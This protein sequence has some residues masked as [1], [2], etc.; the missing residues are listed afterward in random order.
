MRI[1][2]LI[3][4]TA[5]ATTTSVLLASPAMA[6]SLANL[7]PAHANS[8]AAGFS[9]KDCNSPFPDLA[10]SDGW[11]FVLPSSQG[12][13]FV[14]LTLNF[15]GGLV[16][17]PITSTDENSPNTGAGWSGYFDNAGVD[18][19]HAYVSTSPTGLTLL[20]GTAQ[21]TPDG[22]IGSTFNLSHTCPG[23]PA[24]LS[25]SPSA[26][27]SPSPSVSMS[28]M[29]SPS[30]GASTPAPSGGAETGGGGSFGFSLM[31]VGAL[32]MAGGMGVVLFLRRRRDESA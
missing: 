11:H 28:P 12:D 14:S 5:I 6:V 8:T 20:S 27:V 16:V 4:A 13:S 24:S 29:G 26:S 19:K 22:K 2:R 18:E 21:I 1:S 31:G 15:S 3:F 17:G 7:N 25:P 9:S 32:T 10:N 30:N 23:T